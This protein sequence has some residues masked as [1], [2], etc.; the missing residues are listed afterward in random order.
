MERSS[1]HPPGWALSCIWCGGWHHL[2]QG[3][4]HLPPWQ[5][6]STLYSKVTPRNLPGAKS[7]C[8]LSFSQPRI[9]NQSLFYYPLLML[10]PLHALDLNIP[11]I[12]WDCRSLFHNG[13]TSAT[14]LFLTRTI[15]PYVKSSLTN[16]G[17]RYYY[18][19]YYYYY[20]YYTYNVRLCFYM[21]ML[22]ICC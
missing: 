19:C 8:L 17:A 3:Y 2:T 22:N 1:E 4:S 6:C 9:K 12:C 21:L 20:Y 16:D 18:Y 15:L 7:T 14:I 11:A 10:K 5:S 13:H